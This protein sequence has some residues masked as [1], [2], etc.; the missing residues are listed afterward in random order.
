VG[1]GQTAQVLRNLCY[2]V[3]GGLEPP[4]NGATVL[5]ESG[6][7]W[8]AGP[9]AAA[10]DAWEELTGHI[11]RLFGVKLLPPTYIQERGELVMQYEEAGGLRLDLSSAGRGLH[12]TLLLLAYLY[13]NPQTVLL[14]DEP[15]AHLEVLRQRQTYQL[16]TELAASQGSQIIAASHSEVVL[17]EAADRDIVIAFVGQP[18]RMDDRGS[19]ALKALTELGFDQYHQAEQMGWVLYL[20]GATDLRIMQA[21]AAALGHPAVAA[22]ERPFVHYVGTNVPQKAR[23]HFYG[24]REAKPD[25]LGI[26]IFDHLEKVVQEGQPLVELMWDRREIE[27]YLCSRE[28]LM[29]YAR[30]DLPG[31]LFGAAEA[32]RRQQAMA[33]AI[34]EVE[35]ALQTLR[36]PGPWSAEIKASDQFLDPLFESYFRKLGLP[37]VMRKNDYHVLAQ[38]LPAEQIPPEV[39]AKLD[40]IAAV[41]GR[42]RPRQD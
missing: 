28:V 35:A 15:D 42:A 36:Q 9:A 4:P 6:P 17:N 8:D 23:D 29:A 18:H 14:L 26:A 41:A 21:F 33:E 27:N 22:L 5:M 3:Y 38:F 12:Q 1:Q 7:R 40:A 39:A 10:S 32:E 11:R 31:D 24:L 19:Q 25:L 37:N 30:Y 34:A 16:I 2:R 13:A 20:E